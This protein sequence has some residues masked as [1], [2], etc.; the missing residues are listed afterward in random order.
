[1]DERE[2]LSLILEDLES[3]HTP[4]ESWQESPHRWILERPS[5]TKG[6]IAR[7][8]VARWALASG[9]QLS[10]YGTDRQ[11]LLRDGDA[12]YQVKSSTMWKTGRYRFQQFR[13]ISYDYAILLGIAPH[14]IHLW[15]IPKEAIQTHIEG[16]N[17]QHTG[18]GATETDWYE[19]DP[20]NPPFW[21]EEWGGTP[22]AA[23]RVLNEL[24]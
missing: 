10:N 20:Y 9:L 6:A 17:G 18:A 13:K 23:R 8:I 21:L 22:E 24:I 5:G 3:E 2:Y 19:I 12:I 16:S 1:M 7:K 11:R 4:D 15:V 14:E